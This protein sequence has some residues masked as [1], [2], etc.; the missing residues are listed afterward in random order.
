MEYQRTLYAF[1][2]A[3]YSSDIH[4]LTQFDCRQ[5]PLWKPGLPFI[6]NWS[7]C[8][9]C[10]H[11]FTSGYFEGDAERLLLS[12]GQD[13]QKVGVSEQERFIWANLIDRVAA[14]QEAFTMPS[15]NWLDVGLGSGGLVMTASEYGYDVHGLDLRKANVDAL[16]SIGYTAS[17]QTIESHALDF[18]EFYNVISMM[19]VLEHM[20]FPRTA[21]DAAYKLLKPDGALVVS[22]PN[23]NTAVWRDLDSR[24]QN[25]YWIEIEH[26]H[27]FTRKN[28]GL[29]L[30]AHGFSPISYHVSQRYRTCMEIIA[31]RRDFASDEV[32]KKDTI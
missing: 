16:T 22:C 19:D 28:L 15:P 30:E 25:P 21:L 31:M 26:Y 8:E 6:I 13:S 20:P 27:N 4:A 29:L 7:S 17:C 18:R 14:P 1:C 5:H 11:V 23:M 32:M 2:P 12:N 9:K 24:L 3:C 10:G